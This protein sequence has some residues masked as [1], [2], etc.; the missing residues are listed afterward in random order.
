[1]SKLHLLVAAPLLMLAACATTSRVE[2][3]FGLRA[4]SPSDHETPVAATAPAPTAPATAETD[5]STADTL[6]AEAV[7]RQGPRRWRR[8]A[9]LTQGYFGGVS[10]DAKRSGGTRPTVEDDVDVP[11]IGGGAQWKMAGDAVDLGVEGLLAFSWRADS[12]AVAV[13]GGG[14][15][16]A[17]DVDMFVFE[18]FGGPFVSMFLGDSVRVYAA[19]GPL[20]QWSTYE[21]ASVF[22]DGSSSGFG[23]GYYARTGLEFVIGHGTMFGVGMRWSDSQID[24]DS[25]MGDLDLSGLQFALTFSQLY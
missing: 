14:A 17:V 9:L 16:V 20:M 24:L 2:E 18:L 11:T 3:S 25:G 22:N 21:E 23:F 6:E 1:M 10:Y 15:A 19:A 12:T 4:V 7:Q 13:G 8:G 5:A